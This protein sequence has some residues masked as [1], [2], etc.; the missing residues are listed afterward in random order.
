[1]LRKQNATESSRYF[2]V[3][4]VSVGGMRRLQTHRTA[5]VAL[6]LILLD[7]LNAFFVVIKQ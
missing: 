5:K 7:M 1:M 4:I 2:A 3:D 6:S